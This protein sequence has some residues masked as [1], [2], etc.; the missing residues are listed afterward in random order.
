MDVPIWAWT[1]VVAV[2]LGML[3]LDLFV[4]HRH[5]HEVTMREAAL[6]SAL[7]VSLGLAFAVARGC[8]LGRNGCGRVHGRLPHRKE[9][10]GR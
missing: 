5:A 8:G 4:F 2:I 6:T 9:P 10:V 1:A 3:A 7:W